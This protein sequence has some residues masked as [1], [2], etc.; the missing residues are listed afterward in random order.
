MLKQETLSIQCNDCEEFHRRHNK[1]P[2]CIGCLPELLEENIPIY[3]LYQQLKNQL[4]ISP[5]GQVIDIDINSYIKYL[6]YCDIKDDELLDK[7][8]SLSRKVL[9]ARK[10]QENG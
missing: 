2:D 8:I 1:E 10:E 4:I 5:A 7:L 9:L 6:E 3:S